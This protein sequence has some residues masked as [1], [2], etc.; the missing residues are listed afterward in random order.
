MDVVFSTGMLATASVDNTVKIWDAGA[1]HS[2]SAS[3]VSK[4]AKAK[5]GGQV[6]VLA[7]LMTI[8]SIFL[9]SIFVLHYERTSFFET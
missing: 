3:G 4:P 5:K 7:R 2:Q 6:R 1:V 9:F 8:L